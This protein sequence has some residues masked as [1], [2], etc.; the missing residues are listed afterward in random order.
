MLFRLAYPLALPLTAALLLQR[1]HGDDGGSDTENAS[2]AEASTGEPGTSDDTPTS[3]ATS[4]DAT[5]D[6]LATFPRPR[7]TRTPAPAA[8]P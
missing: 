7:A 3:G 2:E 1:L 5:S 6:S 8:T 4:D